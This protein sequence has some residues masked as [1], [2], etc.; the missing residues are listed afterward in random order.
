VDGRDKPGHDGWSAHGPAHKTATA[1][2]PPGVFPD[3]RREKY[4]R[5]M[6]FEIMRL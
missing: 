5:G 4:G 1:A 2:V 3:D 6:R